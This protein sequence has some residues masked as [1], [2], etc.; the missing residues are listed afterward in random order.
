M[1]QEQREYT[2]QSQEIYAHIHNGN[3]LRDKRERMD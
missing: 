1:V 2:E 3:W